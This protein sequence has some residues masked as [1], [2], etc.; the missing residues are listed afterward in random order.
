MAPVQIPPQLFYKIGQVSQLTEVQP[1]VLRYWESEFG[2]V[3]PRKNRVG[4]RLYRRQD[5]DIILQIKDL[6]YNQGYSIRGA[7]QKL[8]KERAQKSASVTPNNNLK[9]ILERHKKQIRELLA[10]LKPKKVN[11]Q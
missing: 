1:H 5:I 8:K 7:K 6:L 3:K 4:Q 9:D 11:D 10:Q 2:L